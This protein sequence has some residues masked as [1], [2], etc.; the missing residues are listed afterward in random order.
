VLIISGT[1]RSG[2]SLWMQMAIAAGFEPI[3]TAFPRTWR[4]H[5]HDHNPGGFYESTL[6]DGIYHKTN[7][8][9]DTGRYLHPD[10]T[11]RHVVKVFLP[12]LA[13]SDHAFL[14]RVVV[15][16]R[17]WR[18]VVASLRR[19]RAHE[20]EV[21]GWAKLEKPITILPPE[22]E[23]L[24]EHFLAVRDVRDRGW[25]RGRSRGAPRPV[26]LASGGVAVGAGFAPMARCSGPLD[27]ERPSAARELWAAVY[28]VRPTAWSAAPTS[29]P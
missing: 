24:T 22:V 28:D 3:G 18:E 6:R 27:G 16:V 21:F 4:Q 9:P 7:P 20:A 15:S 19:M 29:R 23:W 2:T 26:P 17:D 1:K 14:D 25:P 12:G 10:A 11:R 5:L 8:N 13:K